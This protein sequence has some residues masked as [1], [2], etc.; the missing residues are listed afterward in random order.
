[1]TAQIG[2]IRAFLLLGESG[3]AV[4]LTQGIKPGIA[5]GDDL[6]CIGLMAH[7]PD[8]LILGTV[9]YTVQCQGQFHSAQAG[10]QMTASP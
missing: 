7:I 2:I 5:P 1:M 8:N 3:Q 10:S 6:M 4:F 9:K